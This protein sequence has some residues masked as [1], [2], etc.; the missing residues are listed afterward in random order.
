MIKHRL[1]NIANRAVPVDG[2]DFKPEPGQIVEAEITPR[3]EYMIKNHFFRDLGEVFEDP[4][5]KEAIKE[6]EKKA[7]NETS[8]GSIEAP[9]TIK[10]K[11]KKKKKVPLDERMI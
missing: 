2:T 10:K 7:K 3:L 9:T 8:V 6:E 4:S 5:Q 11:G 1:E